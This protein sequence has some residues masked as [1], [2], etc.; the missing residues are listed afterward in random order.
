ML[1]ENGGW[2]ER[3][4]Q[5]TACPALYDRP[6]GHTIASPLTLLKRL[7]RLVRRWSHCDDYIDQRQDRGREVIRLHSNQNRLPE[8]PR[9]GFRQVPPLDRQQVMGLIKDDP[10]RAPGTSSQD[11]KAGKELTE[12]G[13]PIREW[14]AKEID[15]QVDLGIL[16]NGKHLVDANSMIA[17]A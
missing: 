8:L 7:Q 1:I 13:G 11:P 10:M 4:N 5:R 15:I 6:S 16:E 14:N 9:Q 2:P 17:I 12:E 3:G